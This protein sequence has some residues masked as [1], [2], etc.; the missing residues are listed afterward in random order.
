[1]PF[2]DDDFQF[3]LFFGHFVITIMFAT[4]AS[5]LFEAPFIGLEK[6]VFGRKERNASEKPAT[7][8]HVNNGAILPKDEEANLP[9]D[10]EAN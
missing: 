8:G 3:V 7:N 9:K 6:L 2:L 5:L 10:E 1:M 4:L